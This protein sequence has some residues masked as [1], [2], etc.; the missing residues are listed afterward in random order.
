MAYLVLPDN[1]T[2]RPLSHP[3]LLDHGYDSGTIEFDHEIDGRP[4]A[5]LNKGAVEALVDAGYGEFY[6]HDF[7]S[8]D[9]DGDDAAASGDDTDAA[10]DE[11]DSESDDEAATADDSDDESDGES[12]EAADE[13]Q[14]TS[15]DTADDS[16]A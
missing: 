8:A 14:A 6:P 1:Y 3:A 7:D 9:S 16:E 10:A 15:D 2:S 13:T 11:S 4:A 12:G 5:E